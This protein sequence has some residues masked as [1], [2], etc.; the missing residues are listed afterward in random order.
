MDAEL[1]PVLALYPSSIQPIGPTEF[2]GN[3]GGGSGAR[4]WKFATGQG[5]LVARAWPPEHPDRPT[6]AQIHGWLARAAPLGFIP[7]PLAGLDGGTIQ[8]RGGRL[9]EV[10][11]WL[12]GR[13]DPSR[14]PDPLHLHLAFAG[15][16][17]FHR[18]FD[19]PE[20]IGPSPGLRGRFVEMDGLIG[21][22]FDRFRNAIAHAPEGEERDLAS[23]WLIAA[24]D[25]AGPI[26]TWLEPWADRAVPLGP[27]L[28]DARP[29]HFLFDSDRLA[30]L[31]DFGAMGIESTS[32]DLARMMSE[33]CGDDLELRA[34]AQSTYQSVRPLSP[35]EDAAIEAFAR[36]ANLLGGARWVRWGFVE[37][38]RFNNPLALVEGLR[39]SVERIESKFT[40][41]RQSQND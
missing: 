5:P 27:R 41:S 16:A 6:L 4:L 28:R 39:R 30:G 33:W 1:D 36:S 32:A 9:W 11:P 19:P 22:E 40:R 12:P 20:S 37:A 38:R 7:V 31:V 15:L 35:V 18:I 8:G 34:L 17:A 3:S 21:G 10:A 29:D 26:R 25:Q 13:A 24:R 2:L 23:R 14:P